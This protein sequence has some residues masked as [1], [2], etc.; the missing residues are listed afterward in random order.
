MHA[1]SPY[2]NQIYKFSYFLK[3]SI[4]PLLSLYLCFL[5]VLPPLRLI[6]MHLGL[7][8]VLYTYCL[9]ASHRQ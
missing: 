8:I 2:L 5:I 7:C 1:Y 6:M 4:F 9:D 3:I